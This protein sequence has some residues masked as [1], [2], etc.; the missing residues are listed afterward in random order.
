VKFDK[1]ILVCQGGSLN[2]FGAKGVPPTGVN[3]T[4]LLKPAGDPTLYGSGKGLGSAVTEPDAR[5]IH[6]TDNVVGDWKQ[7]DWIA[8]ATTSFSPFETE[9]VK[10]AADPQV[11]SVNGGYLITLVQPLQYYHF[12]GAAPSSSDITGSTCMN[13]GKVLPP[14][15]CDAADK[16]FGVDERAEVG[17]LSRNIKL[18]SAT[19]PFWAANNNYSAGGTIQVRIGPKVYEFSAKAAG[20]SGN[21]QPATWPT[22]KGDTV[23][24]N[25]AGATCAGGVLWTN[26]GP[27]DAAWGGEMR[28]LHKFVAVNIQGVEIAGFGKDTLGAYPIHFHQDGELTKSP[29]VDSNSIHHSYNKCITV[30]STVNLN[31]TNNVCVR[32][33]GHLFYEEIGDEDN[34]TFQGNLGLGA[35]SN[36][37]GISPASAIP[38]YWWKGDNLAA[39]LGYDGLNVPDVDSQSNP[40]HGSCMVPNGGGGED[41]LN[42]PSYPKEETNC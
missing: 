26:G 28:F 18:T 21:Q 40:A 16:N 27:F 24:D 20:T 5:T 19:L 14:F 34:I 10:L 35:T 33:D 3:W 39:S 23:C 17:L 2:M 13:A 15:F 1:G 8:I 12:G 22:G 4:Y 32:A 38:T 31:L 29:L 6:V 37:F 7:G 9:I 30:H 25:G 42:A 41:L 36:N 11:D